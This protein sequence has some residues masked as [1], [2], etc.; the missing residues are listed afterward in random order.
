M[1]LSSSAPEPAQ[2]F[3]PLQPQCKDFPRTRQGLFSNLCQKAQTFFLFLVLAARPV[4]VAAGQ[5]LHID[6][7]D[8]HAGQGGIGRGARTARVKAQ[9]D[10]VQ[11]TAQVYI[12]TPDAK[13]KGP[14]QVRRPEKPL[15]VPG[16]AGTYLLGRT[17][18]TGMDAFLTTFSATEPKRMRS[19]PLRPW[20]PMT[21]RSAPSSL[22]RVRISSAA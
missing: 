5:A 14:P 22:A 3:F 10:G 12:Q 1:A 7:Q 11:G 21:M 9:A 17:V 16:P 20:V 4:L 6:A 19:M 15:S 2:P 18:S 13:K 8:I